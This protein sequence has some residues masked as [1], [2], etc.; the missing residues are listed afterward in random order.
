MKKLFLYIFLVL[1]WCNVG[2]AD[3]FYQ[4]RLDEIK[5]GDS[6]LNYA[7]EVDIKNTINPEKFKKKKFS[8]S[9]FDVRGVSENF[10]QL[11]ISFKTTDKEYK[12]LHIGGS[13]LTNGMDDCISKRDNIL[14]QYSSSLKNL[15]KEGPKTN[16]HPADR[17]GKSKITDVLYIFDSGFLHASCIDWS[18]EIGYK[19]H[20][21]FQIL[22][23]E[24][25]YWMQKNI[26]Y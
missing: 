21:N 9:A 16:N 10:D 5:I 25:M 7:N 19:D 15:K 2:F 24:F 12:I 1:M 14:K 23:K 17:S 3:N 18:E 6:L 4:L 20:L 22:E 26:K 8:T 11:E 13:K